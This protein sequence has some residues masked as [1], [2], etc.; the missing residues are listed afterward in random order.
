M[1]IFF[2]LHFKDTIYREYKTINM[3]GRIICEFCGSDI[4][5]KDISRHYKTKKCIKARGDL[6][7]SRI[8]SGNKNMIM[9]EKQLA[10][11]LAIKEEREKEILNLKE[12]KEKEILELKD[13]I[14]K[15]DEFIQSLAS[16]PSTT[17]TN[18]NHFNVNQYFEGNKGLDFL[19]NQQLMDE[20]IEH[21][22]L[23][24]EDTLE[25]HGLNPTMIEEIKKEQCEYLF[26]DETTGKWNV[27]NTDAARNT[28]SICKQMD[29]G[30]TL[31]VKD[32]K[33]KML[34]LTVDK[35]DKDNK[36]MIYKISLNQDSKILTLEEKFINMDVCMTIGNEKLI[37]KIPVKSMI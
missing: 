29:D 32:P 14:N 4:F 21:C 8:L 5:R 19:D 35:V 3:P 13:I 23:M 31:Y 26:K 2:D 27:I 1:S 9:L 25:N 22:R 28:F 36:R 37:K 12:E 34:K 20:R 10:E 11:A 6:E 16:R 18:N 17:T 30:K 24:M 33:G 15:K 7:K